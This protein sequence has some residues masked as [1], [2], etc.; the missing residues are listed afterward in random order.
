[1]ASEVNVTIPADGEKASKS[2]FRTQFQTIKNE[3]DDLQQ[4]TGIPARLAY[5]T[6]SFNLANR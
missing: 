2:E 5:G 1:M 6:M 3:I 4:K